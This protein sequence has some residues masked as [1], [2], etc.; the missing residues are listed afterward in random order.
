M[1]QENSFLIPQEAHLIRI[2]KA[3]SLILNIPRSQIQSFISQNLVLLNGEVV[4]KQ[5]TCVKFEDNVIIKSVPEKVRRVRCEEIK[6]K[7][8]YEDDDVMV[9]DKPA[10]LSVYPGN[11]HSEK[12]TLQDFLKSHCQNNLSD[13]GGENRLGIVHRL[14]K[15]TSGLMIIAKTNQAH[16][17]IAEQIKERQVKRIYKALVW[18]MIIKTTGTIESYI[19]RDK[20]NRLK[21]R[22]SKEGKFAST[23]YK[24]LKF[25]PNT[26]ISLVECQLDT[27]RTHQI[28]LHLSHIG[29]SIVGDQM[30]GKNDKKLSALHLDNDHP[31]V[32]FKRQALHSAQLSFAHPI[33]RR[34]LMFNSIFP[35]DLQKIISYL[36]GPK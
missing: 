27:G 31:L 22:I 4:T 30:Y 11:Q 6:P 1:N 13:V 33:D 19:D 5:N 34:Q 12:Y 32:Q 20:V 17:N 8:V 9:I 35:E 16:L 7:I 14:D 24:V 23:S 28:R 15:D 29:H 36:E 21:M 2:D 10:G 3:L 26:N 18:G 25:F